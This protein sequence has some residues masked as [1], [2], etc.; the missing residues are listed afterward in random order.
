MKEI[1]LILR[2]KI[3]GIVQDVKIIILLKLMKD[4][5]RNI[6]SFLVSWKI[7]HIVVF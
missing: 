6:F 1:E 2:E 3:I 4:K 5:K 7:L